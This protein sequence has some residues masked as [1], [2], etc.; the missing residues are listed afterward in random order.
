MPFDI[1]VRGATIYDGMG[2]PGY[3]GDV[4]IRGDR[5]VEVGGR[6]GPARHELRADGLAVAPGFIDSHTHLDAQI[7]WDAFVTSSCFHGVTSV[8]VGN[9]GLTLAPCK[10]E[11]RDAMLKTFVRVEGMEMGMLQAGVD[12]RWTDTAGYLD[13]IERA[14]PALNVGMLVGHCALRQYVMGEESVERAATPREIRA[15]QAA[16]RNAM[17]AG[18][19]GF[20]TNQ[21][22]RHM[23]DDGKPLQSRLAEPDEINALGQV[24]SDLNRGVVQMSSA[25]QAA[26]RVAALADFSLAIGRPVVWNAI[27]HIWSN[28][29]LWREQLDATERAFRRGARAWANT[30]ARAFNNRFTLKN[31]QEFDE[32]PAWRAL[33]FTPVDERKEAFRNPDTRAKLRWEALEDPGRGT[34]H[35]R[36]DLVYIIKPAL[37]ENAGLRGQSVA[38]LARARGKDVIDA[39]LDLALEEDLDTV[40][41]TALTNGDPEAVGEIVSSPYTVIGQSDAGA[42]LAIDAG[43]GYCTGLLGTFV[44]ERRALTLEQAVRKLTWMQAQIFGI[45]ERGALLPGMAADLVV[46]DPATVAPREPEL[47]HDLPGGGARLAQQ[48]DGIRLTIV[49]GKVVVENGELTGQR[50][51]KVLRGG[52]TRTR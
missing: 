46:F 21:N 11:D 29:T 18:A 48:A 26:A 52:R 49:N 45:R 27:L 17:R 40:F 36:W 33:M 50:P 8:V 22:P 25:P 41:Q 51:G 34:F 13:T 19:L 28:P 5:I 7:L 32:F 42:H 2:T 38:D 24:L 3:T 44:R 20:S 12:W 43:F 30:N 31:A 39:F 9:C 23:R 1:A 4:A 35:K 15:L 16:L 6:V 47:V 37:P 10:P 14:R